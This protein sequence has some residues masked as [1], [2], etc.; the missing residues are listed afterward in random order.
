MRIEGH[1]L[2][3]VNS[4]SRSDVVDFSVACFDAAG[5]VLYP[6]MLV[7]RQPAPPLPRNVSQSRPSLE[8]NDKRDFPV[9]M[10]R[11]SAGPEDPNPWSSSL[12]RSV[13]TY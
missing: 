5:I 3:G 4:K 1:L 11:S 10:L 9:T 12:I 7:P 6:R 13:P 2:K 8:K